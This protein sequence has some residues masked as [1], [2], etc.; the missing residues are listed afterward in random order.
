MEVYVVRHGESLAMADPA[1]AGDMDSGLSPRGRW[2]ARQIGARLTAVGIALVASSPLIRALETATLLTDAAAI[3]APVEVWPE[4]REGIA[5]TLRGPGR[6]ALLAR[7]PGAVLPLEL[8][9]VGLDYGGE[10]PG[11]IAER[12]ARVWERLFARGGPSDHVAIVTHA[13]LGA[14]LLRHA[15]GSVRAPSGYALSPGSLTTLLVTPRVAPER[16]DD[17]PWAEA[18]TLNDTAHL[19]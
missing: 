6:S 4:L 11:A 8:G 15:L 12:A 14:A 5:G 3:S 7:F 2:Q 9:E 16:P 1:S 18:L 10:S 19:H 13:G 17:A